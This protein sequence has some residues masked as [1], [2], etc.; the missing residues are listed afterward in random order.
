MPRA[1]GG[2]EFHHHRDRLPTFPNDI[3]SNYPNL[4]AW[5]SRVILDDGL[6]KDFHRCGLRAPCRGKVLS[7][8]I[9]WQIQKRVQKSGV[10]VKGRWCKKPRRTLWSLPTNRRTLLLPAHKH[11]DNKELPFAMFVVKYNQCP[12]M[13]ERTNVYQSPQTLHYCQRASSSGSDAR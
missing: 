1:I 8:P 13:E 3:A 11:E 5:G 6:C 9:T 12:I 7:C 4:V 2:H 10:G